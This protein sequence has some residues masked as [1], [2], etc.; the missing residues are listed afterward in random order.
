VARNDALIVLGRRMRNRAETIVG[1]PIWQVVRHSACLCGIDITA[2]TGPRATEAALCGSRDAFPDV[3]V[4]VRPVAGSL[5]G[6]LVAESAG[7]ALVVLGSE[8]DRRPLCL[9][10][11]S[12]GHDV[13][14][15]AASPVAIVN[16]HRSNKSTGG[17][18]EQY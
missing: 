15:F 16:E 6:A 5:S 17:N 9:H 3:E 4:R 8:G 10:P 1:S 14:R 12:V 18:D 2:L 13:I 7:A 11:R